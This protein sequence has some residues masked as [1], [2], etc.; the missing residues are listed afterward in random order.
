MGIWDT[1]QDVCDVLDIVEKGS[2]EAQETQD[3][4]IGL[5]FISSD[6]LDQGMEVARHIREARQAAEQGDPPGRLELA[7][8]VL[9]HLNR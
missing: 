1:F 2:Q 9:G 3:F 7:S 4:L 6:G 5:S 8:K